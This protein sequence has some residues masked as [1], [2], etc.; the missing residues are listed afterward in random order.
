MAFCYSAFRDGE[1]GRI[2]DVFTR[3]RSEYPKASC[4]LKSV[5]IDVV[6]D[7]GNNHSV[8]KFE[9]FSK[10]TSSTQPSHVSISSCYGRVH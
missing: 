3:S 9:F 4:W 10:V 7:N 5:G 8:L 6:I 2:Q 1:A